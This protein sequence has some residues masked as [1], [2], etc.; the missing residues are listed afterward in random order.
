MS[1]HHG[2][3]N[4]QGNNFQK[5]T[6]LFMNKLHRNPNPQ[7]PNTRPWA[8]SWIQDI[9]LICTSFPELF[10]LIFYYVGVIN[11][12]QSNQMKFVKNM[13]HLEWTKIRPLS[14]K[15]GILQVGKD[16]RSTIYIMLIRQI[17]QMT[18]DLAKNN[19][20]IDHF[21]KATRKNGI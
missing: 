21:N 15:F 14:P 7:Q 13:K 2:N 11:K 17:L 1:K 12:N 20:N 10:P 4:S 3:P 19:V 9:N 5:K 16:L 8:S 6:S 18:K